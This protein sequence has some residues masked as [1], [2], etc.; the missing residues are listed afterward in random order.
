MEKLAY[1]LARQLDRRVIISTTTRLASPADHSY[2][3]DHM[4]LDGDLSG[5][6][7]HPEAGEVV[8]F[9]MM[10]SGKI[11]YPGVET[12]DALATRCDVLLLEGDGARHRPLKIH[13]DRDPIVPPQTQLVIALMGLS[14]YGKPLDEDSCYLT[15]R[16]RELTGDRLHTIGAGMYRRLLDHP[17]GVFKG[18]SGQRVVLVLNQSELID[19]ADFDR[20]KTEM[21]AGW[22]GIPYLFV[23]GSVQKDIV[24]H[25]EE[26][27]G[28]HPIKGAN[29]ADI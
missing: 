26:V 27:R 9:G 18:V 19:P 28:S 20:L 10:E 29:C 7:S 21:T 25:Y 11:A 5:L 12:L 24:F 8:L 17:Q 1:R 23:A 16:Y 14:A 22:T 2:P 15:E 4:V 6:D 13:T 3:C